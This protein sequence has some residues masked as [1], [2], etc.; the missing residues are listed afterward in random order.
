MANIKISEL[1]ELYEAQKDYN[2]Y[3]PVVDTSADETKKIS[4]K[5]LI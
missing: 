5:N 3:V 1:N 2:D 4:V